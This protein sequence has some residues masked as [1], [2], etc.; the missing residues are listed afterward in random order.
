VGEAARFE[1]LRDVYQKSK[2][3]LI[4]ADTD[5]HCLRKIER[6]NGNLKST[7]SINFLIGVLGWNK[8]L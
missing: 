4:V 5:N 1:G 7:H 2:N 8:P 3:E 6:Y